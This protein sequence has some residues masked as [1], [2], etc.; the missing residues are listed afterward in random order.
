[1]YK[2]VLLK[3]SGEAL[4]TDIPTIEGNI[5][6]EK[7]INKISGFGII[8][9][10]ML[11]KV[12][13]DIKKSYQEGVEIA[14]VVGG[15]N[16]CRGSRD[17]TLSSQRTNVDRIGMLATIIN[18][19]IVNSALS[20]IGVKS[21]VLSTRSMP[22]ICE[23]YTSSKAK[24]YIE[25]GNVVICAGG[26]GQPFFS[27][28]TAAVIRACELECNALL[29]ATKVDGIYDSDP[30]LNENAKRIENINYNDFLHKDIG[31]MD[32]TSISIAKGEKLPI[33]IFCIYETNSIF[34]AINGTIKK[35][36][37][38]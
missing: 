6:F 36:T 4:S 3:L 33:D 24:Q 35:S 21:V 34:N 25:S 14:L 7:Y 12:I 13:L 16:V 30:V 26:S 1:M 18:G 20:T 28:D 31:I 10:K 38:S 5:E 9:E 37:I 27:T 23:L 32:A 29:K 2:R 15:G 19:L 11:L 8:N 17:A 22:A